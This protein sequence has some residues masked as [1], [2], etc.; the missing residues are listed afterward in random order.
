MPRPYSAADWFWRVGDV[1]AGQVYAS[2]RFAYVP[3]TSDA[4]FLAFQADSNTPTA[5]ATEAE[6]RDVLDAADV[7]FLAQPL[8]PLVLARPRTAS[9]RCRLTRS[10]QSIVSGTGAAIQW[11]GGTDPLGMNAP[12]GPNPD[13]VIVPAGQG[14]LYLISAHGTF[15]ANGTGTRTIQIRRNTQILRTMPLAAIVTASVAT[16]VPALRFAALGAGDIIRVFALQDSGVTLSVDAEL[17][18]WRI[19]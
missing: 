13:R 19:E 3:S 6:L 1:P 2:R 12:A 5:I 15:A 16:E 17:V 4:E 14:G 18:L 9:A 8:R 10:G 7:Q 11:T